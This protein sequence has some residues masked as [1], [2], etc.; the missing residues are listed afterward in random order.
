M[1]LNTAIALPIFGA[2]YLFFWLAA[3]AL[4]SRNRLGPP[5]VIHKYLG[6]RSYADLRSHVFGAT[7]LWGPVVLVGSAFFIANFGWDDAIWIVAFPGGYAF[8]FYRFIKKPKKTWDNEKL[9]GTH[10]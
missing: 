2:G 1:L 4:K 8:A 6:C 5:F 7:A 9:P 10:G 3:L